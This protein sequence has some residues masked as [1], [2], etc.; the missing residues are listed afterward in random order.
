MSYA[1]I[2][3][4]GIGNIFLGDDAF[5]VEVASKLLR[6]SWPP[7]VEVR[8]FGIRSY[9]LAFAIADGYEILILV[10]ATQRGQSPGT[11]YLIEPDCEQ[12]QALQS[13]QVD[14]HRL[15]PVRVLQLAESFGARPTRLYL[16]GCEPGDLGGDDGRVGLT[17][18]V[19]AAVPQAIARIETLVGELMGRELK[20]NRGFASV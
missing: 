3:I 2:L 12:L 15:D 20:T 16:V 8:D 17:E 1:R 7:E 18:P 6:R 13:G 5:G 4:A 9:D 14:A 19:R 10:D 11:L